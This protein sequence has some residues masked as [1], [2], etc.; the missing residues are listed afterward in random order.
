MGLKPEVRNE[1]VEAYREGRYEEIPVQLMELTRLRV[2]AMDE[3]VKAI[4]AVAETY[5]LLAE[6]AERGGE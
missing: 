4:H 1:H 6:G 5:E 2:E 3:A